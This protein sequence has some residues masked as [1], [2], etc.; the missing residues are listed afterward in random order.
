MSGPQDDERAQ[1]SFRLT[2]HVNIL[3]MNGESYRLARR[4]AHAGWTLAPIW[5][6]EGLG[7]GQLLALPVLWTSWVTP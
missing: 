1:P 7:I 2:C 5:L 3:E 6:M 4:R